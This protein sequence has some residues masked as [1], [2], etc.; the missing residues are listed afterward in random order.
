MQTKQTL[1]LVHNYRPST[2]SEKLQQL[3]CSMD[4]VATKTT[5]FPSLPSYQ[6][7]CDLAL[8]APLSLQG[9]GN[10]WYTIHFRTPITQV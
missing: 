9:M 5:C 1:P 3:S 4:M 2:L 8:K 10:A 6:K 7:I